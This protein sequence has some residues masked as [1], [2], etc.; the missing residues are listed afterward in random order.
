MFDQVKPTCT[1][2]VLHSRQG[3]SLGEQDLMKCLNLVNDPQ[4]FIWSGTR[5][6][7]L[8]AKYLIDWIP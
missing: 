3:Q 5:S 1:I 4:C 8:G 7:I 6:H 2:Y